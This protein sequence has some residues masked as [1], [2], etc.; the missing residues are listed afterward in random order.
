[1]TKGSCLCGAVHYQ[2]NGPMRPIIAC[3]C[4]QC[5]KQSGNYYTT[6]SALNADLVIT[7][8]ENITW[9]RASADAARGFCKTCGSA[10]F[11]KADG[12]DETSILAGSIDGPTGLQI[13]GHI[14]CADK[15]D[16][17]ALPEGGYHKPQW[18]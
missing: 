7:G 10:L 3:H 14:Y 4:T 12:R 15:G 8:S 1:M 9:Y 16:Y 2:V 18:D 17:Y 6:T 5:R 13:E 11:W